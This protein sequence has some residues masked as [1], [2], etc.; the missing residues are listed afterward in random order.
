VKGIFANF[1]SV[2]VMSPQEGSLL[3]LIEINAIVAPIVQP[4]AARRLMHRDLLSDF[5]LAVVLQAG[6]N[7]RRPN[8]VVP[9]YSARTIPKTARRPSQ[10]KSSR[11]H[12]VSYRES[13][14]S[15]LFP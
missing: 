9:A 7:S 8:L 2:I 1:S 4:G 15:R 5:Q 12:G 13:L 10:Q 11:M 6:G 14:R 3:Y